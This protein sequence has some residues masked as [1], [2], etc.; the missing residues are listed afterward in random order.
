MSRYIGRIESRS[1][2]DG[3]IGFFISR[4]NSGTLHG[5]FCQTEKPY[6]ARN[7]EQKNDEEK[8]SY[9]KIFVFPRR[10]NGQEIFARRDRREEGNYARSVSQ[11][12]S[13]LNTRITAATAQAI[14]EVSREF[15]NSPIFFRSLVN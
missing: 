8:F 1:P 4:A 14:T 2:A 5:R 12:N 9:S 7:D 6:R 11:S 13:A 3:A 10:H 15:A